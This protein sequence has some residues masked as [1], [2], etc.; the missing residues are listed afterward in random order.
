MTKNI[1]IDVEETASGFK[2]SIDFNGF[3]NDIERVG[4]LIDA[5]TSTAV[6]KKFEYL[7]V[8]RTFENSW[9]LAMKR[10][11]RKADVRFNEEDFN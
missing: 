10:H 6:Q 3:E 1:N 9:M 4:A 5:L 7:L 2:Y 8:K 11:G